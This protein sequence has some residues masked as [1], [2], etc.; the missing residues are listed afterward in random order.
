MTDLARLYA[1]HLRD[2][3]AKLQADEWYFA[4]FRE[5]ITSGLSS[6]EAYLLI[7][8]AVSLIMPQS[9]EYLC[10]EAFELLMSLIVTSDTTGIPHELESR[11]NDLVN[12]VGALGDYQRRRVDEMKKW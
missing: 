12:H 7:P 3:R 11:W 6:E 1:D 2:W 4:R 8:Q 5:R 9:D 10:T